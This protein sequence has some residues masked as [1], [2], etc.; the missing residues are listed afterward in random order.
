[1]LFGRK[2]ISV[3]QKNI[4]NFSSKVF[5]IEMHRDISE[6]FCDLVLKSCKPLEIEEAEITPFSKKSLERAAETLKGLIKKHEPT[7]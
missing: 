3:I 4:K 7:Q 1:M 2:T 5:R 6:E